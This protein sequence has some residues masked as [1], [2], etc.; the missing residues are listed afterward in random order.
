MPG[1]RLVTSDGFMQL[2]PG[3]AEKL[4]EELTTIAEAE[5]ASLQ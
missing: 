4:R 1:Y 2:T 3:L 5:K